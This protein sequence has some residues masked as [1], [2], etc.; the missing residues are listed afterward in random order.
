MALLG[1]G[2]YYACLQLLQAERRALPEG[3]RV[4]TMT[5]ESWRW[6]RP[7]LLMHHAAADLLRIEMLTSLHAWRKPHL[8]PAPPACSLAYTTRAS[9]AF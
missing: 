3:P 9:K 8:A 2:S 6:W 4:E 5:L 1:L 7:G